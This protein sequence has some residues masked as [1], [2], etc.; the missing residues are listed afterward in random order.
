MQFG[1]A[2]VFGSIFTFTA[3][4]IE[5][6]DFP[7]GLKCEI[8]I[9][10]DPARRDTI[11]EL[12]LFVSD[13]KGGSWKLHSRVKPDTH[14]FVYEAPRAGVYSF[15]MVIHHLDGTTYPADPKKLAAHYHIRFGNVVL[16]ESVE[17]EQEKKWA[18][19]RREG[20]L[21]IQQVVRTAADL[22]RRMLRFQLEQARL[23]SA[24]L[25]RQVQE[26]KGLETK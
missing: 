22:D 17:H 13:D 9:H 25:K 7:H 8:P 21:V 18:V 1:F 26:L 14:F 6:I 16:R 2:I 11:R 5:I 20:S 24:A 4:D 12:S 15:S 10:F 3:A 19:V 23:E